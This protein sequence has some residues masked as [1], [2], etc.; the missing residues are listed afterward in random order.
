MSDDVGNYVIKMNNQVDGYA[1]DENNIT[2]K[3][4]EV[5]GN[6][7]VDEV[8]GKHVKAVNVTGRKVSIIFESIPYYTI[9]KI[10]DV[11]EEPVRGAKYIILDNTGNTANDINGKPLFDLQ[12][13]EN[14]Q[15][16]KEITII[17]MLK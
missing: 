12:T 1:L 4:S 9:S 2:L 17:Q 10:D 13:N 16:K 14:G 15:I 6:L 3:V 7:N 5:N 11:T 8:Q